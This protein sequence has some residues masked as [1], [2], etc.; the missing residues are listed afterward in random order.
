MLLKQILLG[1]LKPETPVLHR[2]LQ[3]YL[4]LTNLADVVVTK[5][6]VLVLFG[7]FYPFE[8]TTFMKIRVGTLALT[9]VEYLHL[10]H[11]LQAYSA[12]RSFGYHRLVLSRFLV[13]CS[14]FYQDTLCYRF[15]HY[16]CCLVYK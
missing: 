3:E 13:C 11:L 6:R 5:F 16:L 10:F 9:R 8:Q 12:C 4:P 1:F 14:N 2:R 7:L 15:L